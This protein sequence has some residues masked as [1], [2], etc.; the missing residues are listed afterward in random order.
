[1]LK[2]ARHAPEVGKV[3]QM[4]GSVAALCDAL[5]GLKNQNQNHKKFK[6]E[7]KKKSQ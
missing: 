7:K 6:K 3:A 1:M 4:A 2:R 5:I